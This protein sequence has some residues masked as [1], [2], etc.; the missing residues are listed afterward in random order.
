LLI[1][2]YLN[3]NN[4][5]LFVLNQVPLSEDVW[6]SDSITPRIRDLSI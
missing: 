2:M 5:I 3:C 6:K 1:E 4:K